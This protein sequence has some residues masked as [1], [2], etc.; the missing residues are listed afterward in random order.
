MRKRVFGHTIGIG[1]KYLEEGGIFSPV[2]CIVIWGK[3]T[4]RGLRFPRVTDISIWFENKG[5]QFLSW[6]IRGWVLYG[7]GT[8][9]EEGQR[10]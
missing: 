2:V 6:F 3:S 4:T 9:R 7:M 8:R 5:E 10:I 1:E